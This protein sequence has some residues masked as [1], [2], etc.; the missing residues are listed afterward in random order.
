MRR[1]RQG[2]AL[3]AQAARAQ[4]RRH[5]REDPHHDHAPR[6]L[7][8]PPLLH[9]PSHPRP[10]PAAFPAP[11]FAL[12]GL[13]ILYG[14]AITVWPTQ[15]PPTGI[16]TWKVPAIGYQGVFGIAAG[17]DVV[18]SLMAFF[19][20]RRMKVPAGG[21]RQS[22]ERPPVIVASAGAD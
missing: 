17:F 6:A 18:A 13:A 1:G 20:L 7:P 2:Q 4:G 15:I 12:G 16:A 3:Y 8:H 11:L 5:A 21:E 19:V 22:V 10:A 14:L 9:R